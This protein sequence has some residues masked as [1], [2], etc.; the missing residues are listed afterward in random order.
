M[1]MESRC[2]ANSSIGKFAVQ[3]LPVYF[4]FPTIPT[5]A[6]GIDLNF[7]R[8]F[9]SA[10]PTVQVLPTIKPA[11]LWSDCRQAFSRKL[12][13]STVL[14]VNELPSSIKH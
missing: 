6:R 7:S 14:E 9:L 12:S 5:N 10:V 11:T 1:Q 3:R 13:K 4:Q 2:D 8:N